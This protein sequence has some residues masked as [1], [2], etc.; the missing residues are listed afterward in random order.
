M[1][2]HIL[3]SST[4]LCAFIVAVS[5]YHF[6]SLSLSFLGLFFSLLFPSSLFHSFNPLFFSL[7]ALFQWLL[8]LLE[9]EESAPQAL[10]KTKVLLVMLR[11]ILTKSLNVRTS[12]YG[13]LGTLPV[14]F[15]LKYLMTRHFRLLMLGCFLAK[16]V[17]L[18]LPRFRTLERF[19]TFRL[20]KEFER[21][22]LSFLILFWEK[23]KAGPS[24]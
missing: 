3:S 12:L 14:R 18:V 2:F 4:A 11:V 17:L 5:H 6:A 1:S 19:L 8:L 15:F 13:T 22:C 10:L 7:F 24:G 9:K 21:G 20:D 23:S 16:L